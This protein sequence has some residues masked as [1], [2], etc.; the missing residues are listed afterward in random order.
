MRHFWL[1]FLASA[2]VLCGMM[3]GPFTPRPVDAA[4]AAQ[5]AEIAGAVVDGAG[6]PVQERRYRFCM[7]GRGSRHSALRRVAG[8]IAEKRRSATRPAGSQ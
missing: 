1:S 3:S 6:K 5:R 7:R 4:D 8:P 2:I